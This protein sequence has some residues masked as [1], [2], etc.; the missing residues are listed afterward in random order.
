[1]RS[2]NGE[3]ECGEDRRDCDPGDDAEADTPAVCTPVELVRR[4]DASA[5][6]DTISC[7]LGSSA[8]GTTCVR[9]KGA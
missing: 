3:W 2:V 1:M 9:V 8:A 5:P 4:A 7:R 6:I